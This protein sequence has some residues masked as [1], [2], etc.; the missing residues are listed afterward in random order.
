[1]ERGRE[2]RDGR[3]KE[4]ASERA[5]KGDLRRTAGTVIQSVCPREWHLQVRVFSN[6]RCKSPLQYK[7]NRK[8]KIALMRPEDT[9]I[10]AACYES[11]FVFYVITVIGIMN[12]FN[13][14]II[15]FNRIRKLKAV[16]GFA[17]G[18]VIH[19]ETNRGHGSD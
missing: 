4:S 9:A 1:L 11:F 5:S 15:D 14:I 13:R 18:R 2:E 16:R 7:K 8:K 3:K 17:V 12:D 19:E 6:A 10:W